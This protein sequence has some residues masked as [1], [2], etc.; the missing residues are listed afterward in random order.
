MATIN[1]YDF[2]QT[3][4]TCKQ[5]GY[6]RR[7]CETLNSIL[8]GNGQTKNNCQDFS[9]SIKGVIKSRVTKPLMSTAYV[10]ILLSTQ[11]ATNDAEWYR[12]DILKGTTV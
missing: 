2:M 10:E 4:F 1:L 8:N 5:A 3:C 6:K 7:K 12:L 11:Y 9:V